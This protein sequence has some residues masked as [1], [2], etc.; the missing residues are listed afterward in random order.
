MTSNRVKPTNKDS[1][2]LAAD[3]NETLF[4][5]LG[6]GCVT[7]ASGVVQLYLSDTQD[8][9]RWNKRCCGVATLIKDNTKRSYYIRVYDIKKKQM[10]W[11]QELYNQFRYKSPRNYFHT[12]EC[13][14]QQAGLNFAS[15]DEANLFKSAVEQKL[16]ERSQ[17]KMGNQP[18]MSTSTDSKL[19]GSTNALNT[20]K[21]KSKKEKKK[22]KLTKDDIGT[23]TNFKHL[24]HV[25]WDPN[26]G[27]D[28]N[29]L[30]PDMHNLFQSVGINSDV[31]EDTV[32]FIYDFLE[33]HGGIDAVKKEIAQRPAPPPPPTSLGT[34]TGPPAPP[35]RS[36]GSAA[37][38]PPPP[39]RQ[40][41]HAPPPPP[42]RVTGGRPSSAQRGVAR[43]P[44]A[45]PPPPPMSAPSS[46]PPPP[47]GVPAPPPPPV[48]PQAPAPPPPPPT[49]F[50]PAAPA[51]ANTDGRANLMDAIRMGKKLNAT[52]AD[53]GSNDGGDGHGMLL[54]QIQTGKSLKPVEQTQ[55]RAPSMNEQDG[56]V[57]ALARALA[58]RQKAV[59]GSDDS[60]SD[61]DDDS[62]EVDDDEWDD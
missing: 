23:P 48:A 51:G 12:F 47:P 20:A 4:S 30:E 14:K 34:K 53:Q 2:L 29:N 9:Q 15:E 28:M 1:L 58:N 31:D 5:C 55:S 41:N 44:A 50:T 56:L 22:G 43:P 60:D 24:S 8:G 45:A 17:R 25:G 42:A 54:K 19:N 35:M 26:K 13:E 32:E 3:E 21:S 57:G 6:K 36:P 38:A 33:K 61:D 16:H 40:I 62:E 59:R 52:P 7:L 18:K 10:L 37:P 49:G 11:E 39:A 46:R 27:F